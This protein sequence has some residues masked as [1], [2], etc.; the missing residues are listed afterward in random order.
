[1]TNLKR[2][3][4]AFV[5]FMAIPGFASASTLAEIQLSCQK[6]IPYWNQYVP[7]STSQ[8]LTYQ[9][10]E[11]SWVW[12]YNNIYGFAVYWA[13]DQNF[14]LTI[15]AQ[16]PIIPSYSGIDG[17]K[18][19]TK[20][21]LT[22]SLRYGSAS[23]PGKEIHLN[24]NRGQIIDLFFP[25]GGVVTTNGVGVATAFIN[26]RTQPGTSTVT[27][28]DSGIQTNSP[29]AISWLPAKYQSDFLIT[30]YTIANEK[31]WPS[32]PASTDVCGLPESNSYSSRFLTDTQ[33]QGSG[34]AR[35]GTTIHYNANQHCYNVDSCAR[36]AA[37]ACATPGSSAAV[38]FT[39]VPR[40]ST[41]N[42]AIIGQRRAQD[43]GGRMKGYH[44]DEYVGAQPALC[45]R[46]G[47]RH[48]AVTLINY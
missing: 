41:L 42:V 29:A 44:I 34:V 5:V 3:M 1:M 30:C 22:M 11:K 36:T 23:A 20:S 39:V 37:G 15:A 46:M 18:V 33:M 26:T 17:G 47:L 7:K 38:D 13:S 10:T 21:L 32:A 16:Q 31:D 19:L 35:D 48:S 6:A 4:L 2:L 12:L 14:L 40:S 24:S 25:S 9:N 43:T 45:R 28:T 27:A 8:C